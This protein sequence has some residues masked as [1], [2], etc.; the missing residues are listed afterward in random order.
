MLNGRGMK[1]PAEVGFSVQ[2]LQRAVLVIEDLAQYVSTS[3]D[4]V[5]KSLNWQMSSFKDDINELKLVIKET[6]A[7]L[8][9]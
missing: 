9:P 6:E 5:I 8:H 3:G 7:V 1:T 4:R 2:E